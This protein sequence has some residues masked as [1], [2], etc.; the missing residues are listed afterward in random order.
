VDPRYSERYRELYEKHW[1][2]RARAD[3][4][5]ETLRRLTPPQ[6]FSRILDVG[7]GDGLF[8]PPLREFGEVEG[9]EPDPDLISPTNPNRSRIYNC[10][11]D[12]RFQ[13]GKPYSLVLMLDVLE[14]LQDAT[15]ALR[16]AA[17]LLES[18]GML[19]L[20]VPAFMTFWTQHDALNMHY[21]RYT[22]SRLRKVSAEA[23]LQLVEER[24]I[25]HW[26]CLPKIALR[27]YEWLVR[28][29]P[30]PAQVP[31]PWI[32]RALYWASRVEQKTLSQL[33]MPVGS[34]LLAV[35]KHCG[36]TNFVPSNPGV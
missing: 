21:T 15:S 8:F 23:G 33:S 19:L 12:E 5:V 32:N 24:Y 4:I 2:W 1:W 11:F 17:S 7:C 27:L 26:T 35:A 28:P 29:Q 10:P 3:L 16:H 20:T 30:K 18:D 22:K 14:H 9:V 13:P 6:G 25:Y 34:S 36:R 31:S